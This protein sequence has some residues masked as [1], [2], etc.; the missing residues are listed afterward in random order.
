M[1]SILTSVKKAC[2]ITESHEYF[3]DILIM[4]T[5]SVFMILNQL[6]VG[7][8]EGFTIEDASDD[9]SDFT[10]DK[11]DLESVKTYVGLKVRLIFDPPTSSAVMESMKQVINELEFRLSAAVDPAPEVS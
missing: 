10:S 6:G 4:H 3:D 8:S 9:W 5:N 11:K 1:G 7:P 2:G